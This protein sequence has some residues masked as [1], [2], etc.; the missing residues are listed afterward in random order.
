MASVPLSRC[1]PAHAGLGFKD[2]FAAHRFL[3]CFLIINF[4]I[5]IGFVNSSNSYADDD[6]TF[7]D[8]NPE[9]VELRRTRLREY[10]TGRNLPIE[11]SG[12][13]V[14]QH[15][16]PVANA[17]V[18][19][20]VKSIEGLDDPDAW[21]RGTSHSHIATTDAVGAF[22][23]ED[24]DGYHLLIKGIEKPGYVYMQKHPSE[25]SVFYPPVPGEDSAP[26]QNGVRLFVLRKKNPD[27]FLLDSS[28]RLRVTTSQMGFAIDLFGHQR[29][30]YEMD[31]RPTAHRIPEAVDLYVEVEYSEE[32]NAYTFLF[33]SGTD[34]GG[35]I[36]VNEVVHEA[37]AE[38]YQDK[39]VVTIAA[40]NLEDQVTLLCTRTRDPSIY[41]MLKFTFRSRFSGEEHDLRVSYA[42]KLNPYGERNLETE[43]DIPPRVYTKL[44][45]ISRLAINAGKRPKKPDLKSLFEAEKSRVTTAP[46]TRPAWK[47]SEP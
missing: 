23:F 36:L 14:D 47:R 1:S 31:S 20:D 7:H 15:G 43:S 29:T 46:A 24:L 18:R 35:M 3:R 42:G 33:R 4:L 10:L 11:F 41:G 17:N 21:P 38:G 37:P 12:R 39:A 13:V 30:V 40:G 9:E 26:R 25:A 6:T 19:I 16:K 22:S 2:R 28:G 32:Q 27:V 5:G 34:T 44:D 45:R 8:P